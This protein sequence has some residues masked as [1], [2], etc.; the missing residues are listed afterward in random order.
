MILGKKLEIEIDNEAYNI[1]K[2]MAKYNKLKLE[3][4]TKHIIE[5]FTNDG[6]VYTGTWPEG[7]GIR[8][9]IDYPKYTSRVVK[10]YKS[11]IELHE[12]S[13]ENEEVTQEDLQ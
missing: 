9:I 11:E 6:K 12:I 3:Q 13:D 2:A 4:M 7:P 1:L 5:E 10:L 8:I